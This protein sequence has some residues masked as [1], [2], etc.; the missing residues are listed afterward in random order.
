M[1]KPNR[2]RA[3]P[4]AL[5]SAVL[6]RSAQGMGQREIAAWLKAE[7]GISISHTSVGRLIRAVT[8]ERRETTQHAVAEAVAKSATSDLDIL[9]ALQS[10]L[11]AMWDEA[12]APDS[13]TGK[14]DIKTALPVAD[15]LHAVTA[16]KLK[17]AG[18]GDEGPQA[19]SQSARDEL[20]AKMNRL[21]ERAAPEPVPDEEDES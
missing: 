20:L 3:I 7:H 13:K 12:K 4:P 2:Q 6:E 11:R 15:R 10:D 18:F 8:D 1:G 16:T 9:G 21:A 5:E 14:R 17:A 19:P